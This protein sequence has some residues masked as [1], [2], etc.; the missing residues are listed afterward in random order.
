MSQ[1]AVDAIAGL[2]GIAEATKLVD[3]FNIIDFKESPLVKQAN[4][5]FQDARQKGGDLFAAVL[6]SGGLGAVVEKMQQPGGWATIGEDLLD[7]KN[8]H[9]K[10]AKDIIDV[11]LGHLQEMGQ[12]NAK[13]ADGIRSYTE[14]F[15]DKPYRLC[16]SLD[17]TTWGSLLNSLR[18]DVSGDQKPCMREEIDK[19][20]YDEGIMF[21]VDRKLSEKCVCKGCFVRL[22]NHGADPTELRAQQKSY[23]VYTMPSLDDRT[24]FY[25][26]DSVGLYE[27]I[28][29]EAA[30]IFGREIANF[31]LSAL[32]DADIVYLEGRVANPVYDAYF[33]NQKDNPDLKLPAVPR[34][35]S[36]AE[37]HRVI[38][39]KVM[40][41][42]IERIIANEGPVKLT[43][44]DIAS[45]RYF[46]EQITPNS[47]V[48]S[49]DQS[50]MGRTKQTTQDIRND[51]WD[52]VQEVPLL[53]ATTRYAR[54]LL[55]SPSEFMLVYFVLAIIRSVLCLV[56][57]YKVISAYFGKDGDAKFYKS[58]RNLIV[59]ALCGKFFENIGSY[60]T[61][62]YH[63]IT[64]DLMEIPN[65]NTSGWSI[66]DGVAVAKE[67]LKGNFSP[68]GLKILSWLGA[69]ESATGSGWITWICRKFLSARSVLA[70]HTVGA[71][72]TASQAMNFWS[73][74]VG[75]GA[76]VASV[77]ALA[78]AAPTGGGSLAMYAGIALTA[79]KVGWSFYSSGQDMKG[80]VL[81]FGHYFAIPLEILTNLLDDWMSTI[82]IPGADLV[83]FAYNPGSMTSVLQLAFGGDMF[84]KLLYGLADMVKRV[85]FY[86]SPTQMVAQI[87]EKALVASGADSLFRASCSLASKLLPVFMLAS[88]ILEIVRV[89][90][91]IRNYDGD[92]QSIKSSACGAFIL[93]SVTDI[94]VE[95]LKSVINVMNN[96]HQIAKLARDD[97][98]S[99][100]GHQ[101]HSGS[102]G[103]EK[104]LLASLKAILWKHYQVDITSLALLNNNNRERSNTGSFTG[105]MYSFGGSLWDRIK[106]VGWHTEEFEKESVNFTVGDAIYDEMEMLFAENFAAYISEMHK[107]RGGDDRATT[108]EEIDFRKMGVKGKTRDV[109]EPSPYLFV[110][111]R[112]NK[113]L[114][115]IYLSDPVSRSHIQKF[116]SAAVVNS[117][118]NLGN[119][120]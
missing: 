94:Y 57:H 37:I 68:I 66:I 71:L 107:L 32:P 22:P 56:L 98:R 24:K 7:F 80:D 104:E 84:C 114:R 62:I 97:M 99:R 30:A 95:Q 110:Q 47:D 92:M 73:E 46:A 118:L 77:S 81:S 87:V 61:T 39:W 82:P 27:F 49:G 90:N 108:K 55:L 38:N 93:R 117:L 52:F 86:T 45:I 13:V 74:F 2:G 105:A 60:L 12:V 10:R 36:S 1:F 8:E 48:S 59:T 91:Q 25:C 102:S 31:D 115:S 28:E 4:K 75:V 19:L 23:R 50:W 58:Q 63:V 100:L 64:T 120:F 116:T 14:K 44:D 101:L 103:F 65:I 21:G 51:V 33:Q 109:Y 79:S 43:I 26:V 9:T 11:K 70:P 72:H 111:N 67:M 18:R 5:H 89:F 106:G 15:M 85:A 78:L 96:A 69:T 34:S 35:L 41:H 53:G 17:K 29:E 40:L 83:D 54:R 112:L 3:G 113:E 42:D 20:F 16:S 6:K 88:V 119:V 76:G